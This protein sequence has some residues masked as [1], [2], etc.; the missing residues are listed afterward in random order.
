MTHPLQEIN[1]QAVEKVL[2]R[3]LQA[4]GDGSEKKQARGMQD[5]RLSQS[6][7]WFEVSALSGR[8]MNTNA[9][10]S[11]HTPVSLQL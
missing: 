5:G 6:T 9:T 2:Q 11:T 4:G 7:E 8:V 1:K 3:A 10:S